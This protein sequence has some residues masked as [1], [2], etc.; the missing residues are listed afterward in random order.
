MQKQS[1]GHILTKLLN[2]FLNHSS[3]SFHGFILFKPCFFSYHSKVIAN[4]FIC[5]SLPL[6]MKNLLS[7]KKFIPYAII[8]LA[9]LFAVV[10][11]INNPKVSLSSN[12]KQQMAITLPVIITEDSLPSYLAMNQIIQDLPSSAEIS[13]KTSQNEYTIT[14]GKVI[15][16]KA[17]NPDIT[18]SIPSKYITEFS[19]GFCSTID[20][21]NRNKDLEI[22]LHLS[23]TALAWK[24]K[25]LF[26]Y[27]ECFGL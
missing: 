20:K 14:K 23:E 26:K 25:S 21:S 15:E 1:A 18:I 17:N 16:A 9:I 6:S 8:L 4:L 2:F 10:I 3:S 19:N 24:Y 13:L 22:T 11:I 5:T 27:R 12:F 7:L